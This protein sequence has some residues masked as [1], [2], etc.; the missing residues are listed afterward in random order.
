MH[1]FLIKTN[2]GQYLHILAEIKPITPMQGKRT[3]SNNKN[4]T[5]NERERTLFL[6][7]KQKF[8]RKYDNV[9]LPLYI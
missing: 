8:H 6:C 3:K 9:V 1:Q 4:E 7:Y 2:Q 5:G